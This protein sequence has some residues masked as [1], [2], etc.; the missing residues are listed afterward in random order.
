MVAK[1]GGWMKA[2]A[3]SLG[4]LYL[5]FGVMELVNAV[6][7]VL[8]NPGAERPPIAL[9]GIPRGDIFGALSSIVIGILLLMPTVARGWDALAYMLGG[10]LLATVFG[11][12]YVLIF[13][14]TSLSALIAG[15]EEL[16]GWLA[17]VWLSYALR[18]EIWLF[19]SAIPLTV[20]V[21]LRAR[22]AG[23]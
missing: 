16:Q 7:T 8:L 3:A 13:A 2:Y 21:W 23:G 4:G 20:R 5:A 19:I 18:P 6:Y 15:G 22:K 9:V 10:T 11:A 14:S 1:V 12:L 17:G